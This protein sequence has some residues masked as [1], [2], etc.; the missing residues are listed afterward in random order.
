M[1]RDW[2]T[3]V[4]DDEKRALVYR[5][6]DAH[7]RHDPEAATACFTRDITNH[8]RAAGR[9]GMAT[10]YRSLYTAFPDY[11]FDIE[12]L[13]V[14]GDWVTAV[15]RQTGT[16]LGVPEL[17]VLGGLLN[18]VP[19]TGKQVS[20]PNIHVYRFE[21]GLIAEHRAVRDDLGMMQQLGLIPTTSHPAGD[22]SRP[23]R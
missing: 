5:L 11:R 2:R 14:D 6:V 7:N 20:V 8:G 16:H 21:G 12:V 10:I 23:A 17:P 1:D 4:T 9:E 3:H 19:P 15:Y 22:I 13:L 18:G